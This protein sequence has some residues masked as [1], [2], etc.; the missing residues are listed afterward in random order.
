MPILRK[1]T[2]GNLGVE[3]TLCPLLTLIART[4]DH[5]CPSQLVLPRLRTLI[6]HT[7]PPIHLLERQL[8]NQLRPRVRGS[9]KLLDVLL[10]IPLIMQ[11][12]HIMLANELVKVF[13]GL[14]NVRFGLGVDGEGDF[15]RGRQGRAGGSGA[16]RPEVDFVV[17]QG[18]D[19]ELGHTEGGRAVH[20]GVFTQETTLAVLEHD[21]YNEMSMY[22]SII[23]L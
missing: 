11:H 23:R 9:L 5:L 22:Q 7:R 17:G 21:D 2:Y 12:L 19:D 6:A 3:H 20:A 16:C 14:S 13:L 8:L 10:T 18:T 4:P 1:A 15:G